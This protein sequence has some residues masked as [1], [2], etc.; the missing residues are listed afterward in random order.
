MPYSSIPLNQ[1]LVTMPLEGWYVRSVWLAY[2]VLLSLWCVSWIANITDSERRRRPW[3]PDD[4]YPSRQPVQD[5]QTLVSTTEEEEDEE[6]PFPMASIRDED[7][8]VPNETTNDT[9]GHQNVPSSTTESSDNRC[10]PTTKSVYTNESLF[11][12]YYKVNTLHRR[13][14]E[15]TECLCDQMTNFYFYESNVFPSSMCIHITHKYI[16]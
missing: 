13:K 6:D 9:K 16:I 8:K 3:D 1:P 4:P 11:Q 14:R 5:E 2:S 7:E 15:G 12:T 10:E